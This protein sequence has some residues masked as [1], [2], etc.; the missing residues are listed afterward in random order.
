MTEGRARRTL[1]I[2]LSRPALAVAFL[3]AVALTAYGALLYF[4]VLP[5]RIVR[6]DRPVALLL[7]PLVVGF[8]WARL[9]RAEAP[10]L[11]RVRRALVDVLASLGLLA[12]VLVIAGVQR[13][14]A[15]NKLTVIVVVDRSRSV[16]LVPNAS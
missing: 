5:E 15:Q 3:V 8:A 4:R 14:E 16:D 11:G 1:R 6:F 2:L 12:L 7:A 10:K 9:V 13:G